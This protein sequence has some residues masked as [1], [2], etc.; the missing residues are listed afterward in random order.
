MFSRRFIHGRKT[1]RNRGLLF[2]AAA[3]TGMLL[4]GG[5]SA[6]QT[7]PPVGTKVTVNG[8]VTRSNDNLCW[9]IRDVKTGQPYTVSSA[10]PPFS[11]FALKHLIHLTGTI[12]SYITF[13]W[14]G[15]ILK[16]I[17]WYMYIKGYCPQP[18][19]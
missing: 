16:D 12:E 11:P 9:V 5:A 17:K 1:M 7:F 6:Q 13:C 2:A 18:S 10:T 8:C 14:S 15:P 19:K 3:L 4:T